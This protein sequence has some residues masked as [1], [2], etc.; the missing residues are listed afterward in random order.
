MN[1][2]SSLHINTRFTLK[3]PDITK[4]D[5]D[6]GEST[7][8]LSSHPLKEAMGPRSQAIM[9]LKEKLLLRTFT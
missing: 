4:G 7:P 3:I 2:S 6:I 8:Q 1:K 9:R 5:D